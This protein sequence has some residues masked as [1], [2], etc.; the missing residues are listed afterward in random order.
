MFKDFP[1]IGS[2]PIKWNAIINSNQFYPDEERSHLLL[3]SSD[4]ENI[5]RIQTNL[6]NLSIC[7]GGIKDLYLYLAQYKCSAGIENLL[8]MNPNY[9]FL[10]G[11]NKLRAD[12]KKFTNEILNAAFIPAKIGN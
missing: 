3:R 6:E 11:N 1:L 2:A 7:F 10:N 4:P 9:E 5:I 8:I 12:L